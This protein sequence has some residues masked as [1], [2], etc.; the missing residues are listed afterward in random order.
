MT[1]AKAPLAVTADDKAKVYGAADSALTYT[2]NPAQ[3][4]YGDGASVVSGIGLAAPTDAAATAGTHSITASGGAAANYS[5]TTQNGRLTVTPAPLLI[6]ADDKTRLYL[7]PDPVFTATYS[8]FRYGDTSAVVSGL[9][10]TAP[11]GIA[12]LAGSYPIV[13]G[14]ASTANYAIEYA[15]GTLNV[16]P[17]VGGV[18]I[19]VQS[20]I[21]AL[22]A[23]SGV[24]APD[25][26]GFNFAQGSVN[27]NLPMTISSFL[28]SLPPTAAGGEGSQ[29][30]EGGS[31]SGNF[32][33]SGL[34]PT[35]ATTGARGSGRNFQGGCGSYG[36]LRALKCGAGR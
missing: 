23:A 33:G 12:I 16:L 18:V 36:P 4:F 14:A 22:G 26:A 21:N 34:R 31:D 30:T 20:G 8:G 15:N 3:L 28:S 2:V 29:D 17:N 11:R 7:T 5:V 27:I 10:F 32:I 6:S 9:G 24:I 1:V 25:V 35:G 13:P 19:T